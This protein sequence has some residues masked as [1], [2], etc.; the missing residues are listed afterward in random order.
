MKLASQSFEAEVKASCLVRCNRYTITPRLRAYYITDLF[1]RLVRCFLIPRR[2]SYSPI[3]L[4]A[5]NRHYAP[6]API[7]H[8]ASFPFFSSVFCPRPQRSDSPTLPCTVGCFSFVSRHSSS[9]LRIDFI[10]QS[11]N[12]NATLKQIF[13]N[14]KQIDSEVLA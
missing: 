9:S 14:I 11:P 4:T 12:Y 13:P 6:S 2:I 5:G 8:S 10:C 7:T 1:R 3:T